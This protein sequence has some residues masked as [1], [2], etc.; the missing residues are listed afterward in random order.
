M[1]SV[2]DPAV[3]KGSPLPVHHTEERDDRLEAYSSASLD[4]LDCYISCVHVYRI[5]NEVV[6]ILWWLCFVNVHVCCRYARIIMYICMVFSHTFCIPDWAKVSLMVWG[7][8]YTIHQCQ[9][10]YY[11]NIIVTL[12]I[13]CVCMCCTC[14][15]AVALNLLELRDKEYLYQS[16]INWERERESN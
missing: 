14:T 4:L 5:C 16:A 13:V 6:R 3:A 8:S 10:I 9:V 15:V 7:L 2:P 11:D 1:S 12:V